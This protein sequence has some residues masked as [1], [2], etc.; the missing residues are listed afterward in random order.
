MFIKSGLRAL[1]CVLIGVISLSACAKAQSDTPSADDLFDAYLSDDR[2]LQAD[3]RA[4]QDNASLI[5]ELDYRVARDQRI[6][7]LIFELL[8]T[9]GAGPDEA[10]ITWL[11]LITRMKGI[12]QDNGA[13]MKDQL[14]HKDWFTISEYGA[15]ADN[16]A[17]L[18]VQH[19]EDLDFQKQVL[20][21]FER[22][23][24]LGEIAP[25]NMALLSDRIAVNEG[26]PQA[27]GSQ[28]ECKNG[29]QVLQTP[30]SDPEPVVDARRQEVGLPSLE[31]YRALLPACP[32]G[33]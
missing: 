31:A 21:R 33:E 1:F 7:A 28:F 23:A 25:D 15:E 10:Q 18:I 19:S 32:A 14:A 5:D 30:L 29:A 22:L 8:E 9:P 17:F 27:Y 3:W 16:Q 26:Q 13:W 24:P 12:D 6:R 11:R 4:R 2:A 20:Q